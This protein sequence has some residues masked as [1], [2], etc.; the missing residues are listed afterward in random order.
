MPSRA[1]RIGK[2]VVDEAH[3]GDGGDLFIRDQDL[4][5]F[6]LRVTANGGKSYFLE[7]RMG[8]RGAAKGRV[9]IGKHGSPWTPETARKKAEEL[10]R[11]VKDGINPAVTKRQRNVVAVDL[12][13]QRYA[14]M[15][16]DGYAKKEQKRSWEQAERTLAL[17]V[18]PLLKDRPL[19]DIGRREIKGILEGIA[20]TRPATARYAHA[21]L[22]KLFKWAVDRGDIAV[23]PMADMKAP[24]SVVSRDRVLSDQ[25]LIACWRA[26]VAEGAPF[27][28]IVQLLI[29]TGQRREEVVAMDWS[30][31]GFD[32]ASWVI[33]AERSKNGI[34]HIVPL[35]A[36][37]LAVLEE[38]GAKTRR[39]GL[40][41]TTTGKTAV[42]GISKFKRR[43]DAAMLDL[44]S[45]TAAEAGLA[46]EEVKLASWRL[47]DIRRTVATGLQ[48]LGVRF[49]VTEAVL[50]HVSG[51]KSGISGVYQRY[52]WDLEKTAALAAWSRCLEGLVSDAGNTSNIVAINSA[53][54]LGLV[55]APSG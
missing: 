17:N 12:A 31:I 16:V 29:A 55:A 11:G 8:G 44:L 47:H 18:T 41:F 46:T 6:G 51:A 7:F 54:A 27:G 26:A 40:V 43:L 33:P 52:G 50:N 2:R 39:R 23:S 10:L 53:K 1:A 48:K 36:Q 24:A 5:G 49:E 45:E 22:R 9:V 30:E 3:A 28:R 34:A 37:A 42:S 19:P 32:N 35:N 15:F 4:K 20:S 25:E 38:L 21:T 13:F 14:P